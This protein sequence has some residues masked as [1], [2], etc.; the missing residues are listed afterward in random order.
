MTKKRWPV[1]SVHGMLGQKFRILHHE[2]ENKNLPNAEV[3]CKAAC[4]F[5]NENGKRL[6]SDAGVMGYSQFFILIN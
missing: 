4:Y 1:E 3:I 5:L 6:Y 2:F